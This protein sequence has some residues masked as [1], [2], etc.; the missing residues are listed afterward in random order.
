MYNGGR[1]T[2]YGEM[3]TEGQLT[4][5]DWYGGKNSKRRVDGITQGSVVG[6]ARAR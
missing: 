5:S 6:I 3:G 1:V 2:M 4:Q